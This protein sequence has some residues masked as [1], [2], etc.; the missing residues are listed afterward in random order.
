MRSF[1][2]GCA[3][4]ADGELL[5]RTWDAGSAPGAGGHIMNMDSPICE[6][7]GLHK[8]QVGSG[9]IRVAGHLASSREKHSAS[10][11]TTTAEGAHPEVDRITKRR[12]YSPA[13]P[14]CCD[15]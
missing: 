7:S 11:L 12:G 10:A 4:N 3:R 2:F 13:P 6:V 14:L 5:Q 1:S 9:Y 15:R 8:Q